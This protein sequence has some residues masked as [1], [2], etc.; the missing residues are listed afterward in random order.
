MFNIIGDK[1]PLSET[2][3][4]EVMLPTEPSIFLS[5]NFEKKKSNTEFTSSWSLSCSK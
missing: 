3:V 5:F 1:A 4:Y 2:Q